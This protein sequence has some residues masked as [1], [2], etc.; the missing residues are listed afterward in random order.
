MLKEKTI[1]YYQL[2]TGVNPYLFWFS[3]FCA[4]GFLYVLSISV[5]LVF[6]LTLD[7]RETFITNG[8]T[9]KENFSYFLFSIIKISLFLVPF[10]L[11]MFLFGISCIVLSYTLSF[12]SKST[13]GGFTLVLITHILFGN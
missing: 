8:S 2:M 10:M 6:L 7:Q 5:S 11:I 1:F 9:C 3:N 12:L 13:T 4:D